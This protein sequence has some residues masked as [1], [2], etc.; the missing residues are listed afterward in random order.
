MKALV[1]PQVEAE[2]IVGY[3]WS[4][5][6]KSYIAIYEP[7]PN[8][9]ILCDFTE[10]EFDVAP[11]LFWIDCEE[12]LDPFFYYYDLISKTIKYIDHAEIPPMP[13]ADEQPA[14]TGLAQA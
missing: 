14:T 7:I 10:V 2:K 3:V 5:E 1:N 8:S 9:A 6:T 11:P 12:R 13:A 4:S